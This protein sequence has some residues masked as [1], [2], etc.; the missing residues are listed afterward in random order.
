MKTINFIRQQILVYLHMNIAAISKTCPDEPP[1][2]PFPQCGVQNNEL[3]MSQ[4][5]SL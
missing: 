5:I 2:E 1:G 4:I 3:Q